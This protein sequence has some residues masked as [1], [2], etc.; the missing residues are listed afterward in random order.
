MAVKVKRWLKE[1]WTK[2]DCSNTILI[3]VLWISENVS[4]NNLQ[5]TTSLDA[6]GKSERLSDRILHDIIM[7]VSTK[8]FLS[9]GAI[10]WRY[11]IKEKEWR[12]VPCVRARRTAENLQ[13]IEITVNG[14]I[15]GLLPLNH[16]YYQ[17]DFEVDAKAEYNFNK[18]NCDYFYGKFPVRLKSMCPVCGEESLTTVE[19]VG[20][21]RKSTPTNPDVSKTDRFERAVKL[22]GK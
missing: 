8:T 6:L 21:N 5:I 15:R 18:L 2:L 10:Y 17:P 4:R 13:N 1:G 19:V 12:G 20:A 14:K 22:L 11:L 3:P 7:D 9:D 16:P